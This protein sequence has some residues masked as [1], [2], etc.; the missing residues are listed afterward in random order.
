MAGR[1]PIWRVTMGPYLAWRFRRIGSSSEKDLRS[2]S[3]FPTK[4]TVVGPGGRF[5]FGKM[6]S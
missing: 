2:H 5:S 6:K 4:G 1:E 3:R